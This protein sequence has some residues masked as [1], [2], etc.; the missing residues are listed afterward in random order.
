MSASIPKKKSTLFT[1]TLFKT[2]LIASISIIFRLN[3]CNSVLNVDIW[4]HSLSPMPIKSFFVPVWQVF[5]SNHSVLTWGPTAGAVNVHSEWCQQ[6]SWS[7]LFSSCQARA[8]TSIIID[9]SK[10]WMCSI[11]QTVISIVLS[12]PLNTRS[13]EYSLHCVL[14]IFQI[15]VYYFISK[16]FLIVWEKTK[17]LFLIF[18]KRKK[19]DNAQT[20]LRRS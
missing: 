2:A 16:G 5:N 20:N 9:F 12:G 11:R 3:T 13:P 8:E 10:R 6:Y 1:L 7:Q 19:K 14:K 17:M 15:K 4:R 18:H